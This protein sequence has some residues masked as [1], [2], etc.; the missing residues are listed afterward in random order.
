[1]AQIN[2]VLGGLI[3]PCLP[4]HIQIREIQFALPTPEG[5]KGKPVPSQES[6][7]LVPTAGA[8]HEQAVHPTA[9]HHPLVRFSLLGGV[10]GTGG[11]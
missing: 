5:D 3:H 10:R 4:I 6:D 2:E 7:P 8:G 11:D 1:M 9:L